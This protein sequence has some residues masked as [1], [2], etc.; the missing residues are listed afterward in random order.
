MQ[1][2]IPITE[3]TPLLLRKLEE[4]PKVPYRASSQHDHTATEHVQATT[5]PSGGGPPGHERT[6][7]DSD[8]I[9][10]RD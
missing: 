4:I 8:R 7:H 5:Y 6:D 10:D 9:P 3:T 1:H 2:H